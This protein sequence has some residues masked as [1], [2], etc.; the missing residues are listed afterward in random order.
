MDMNMALCKLGLHLWICSLCLA[1]LFNGFY[2]DVLIYLENKLCFYGCN[3]KN[4]YGITAIPTL[5]MS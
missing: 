2:I 4:P 1:F 5:A 3:P